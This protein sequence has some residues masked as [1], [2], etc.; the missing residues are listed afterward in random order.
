MSL[1]KQWLL[2]AM[3]ILHS[4]WILNNTFNA[5]SYTPHGSHYIWCILLTE[6][7]AV[8]DVI[9]YTYQ[10]TNE[11]TYT[12]YHTTRLSPKILQKHLYSKNISLTFQVST[13]L[14]YLRGLTP[15]FCCSSWQDMQWWQRSRIQIL[16]ISHIGNRMSLLQIIMNEELYSQISFWCPQY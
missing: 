1:Q 12:L 6:H 11:T 8:R 3:K 7:S 15:L 5:P 2:L 13:D 10:L 9:I 4:S 14:L 16:Y